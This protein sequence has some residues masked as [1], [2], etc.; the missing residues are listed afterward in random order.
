MISVTKCNVIYFKNQVNQDQALG[1]T[2]DIS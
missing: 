2:G 1:E